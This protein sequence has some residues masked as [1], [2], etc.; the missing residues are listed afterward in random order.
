MMAFMPV[1]LPRVRMEG[2]KY[3]LTVALPGPLI[4][5]PASGIS[6]AEQTVMPGLP[7]AIAMSRA[8]AAAAC[9]A[10]LVLSACPANRRVT[11]LYPGM[12]FDEMVERVGLPD[13]KTVMDSAVTVYYYTDW[14]GADKV[15]G[16]AQ[17]YCVFVRD[18][19]VERFQLCPAA[20]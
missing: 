2:P 18:S 1:A 16:P 10:L 19:A 17:Y 9:L 12:S 11:R 14:R 6:A 20:K 13:L 15:E 5:A 7:E 4:P 3:S 8:A